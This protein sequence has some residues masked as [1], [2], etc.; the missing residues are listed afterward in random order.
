[1]LYLIHFD[2]KL[3]HAQHYIGFARDAKTFPRRIEHHRRGSGARLM[4]AVVAAGIDFQVVRVWD[5]GDRNE[6]RRLK[7]RHNGPRLCP[8]CAARAA[9]AAKA[10][11]R[12]AKP[13][14]S[15]P[16]ATRRPQRRAA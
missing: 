16:K 4:A 7:N 10:G 13:K 2:R 3:H 14:V 9:A 6:E 8:H 1:M 11:K 5:D 15:K 12:R